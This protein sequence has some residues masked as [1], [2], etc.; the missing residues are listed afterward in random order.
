M[1][2]FVEYFWWL[3][4]KVKAVKSPNKAEKDLKDLN[5]TGLVEKKLDNDVLNKYVIVTFT[6]VA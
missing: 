1:T 6:T 4:R 3:M 2:C 5:M